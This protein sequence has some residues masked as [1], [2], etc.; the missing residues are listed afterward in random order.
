[1]NRVWKLFLS[2]M[3]FFHLSAAAVSAR[4]PEPGDTEPQETVLPER[5]EI[6]EEAKEP[7]EETSSETEPYEPEPAGE[8]TGIIGEQPPSEESRGLSEEPEEETGGS[9]EDSSELEDSPG[10]YKRTIMLYL[11]GCD[12]ETNTGNATR[13]LLQML[14]ASFSGDQEIC[15]LV[16]TGGAAAGTEGGSAGPVWKMESRYL[17]D[18]GSELQPEHISDE[19]NQVWELRGKDAAEYASKMILLDADGVSG[20]GEDAK[21]SDAE[22]M[23]DPETLKKFINY[24]VRKCPAEK[25]DLILWDH[26]GGFNNGFALDQHDKGNRGMMRTSGFFGALADNEVTKNGGKFE[27]INFDACLM[28]TIEIEVLLSDYANYYLASAELVPGDGEYYTGWLDELGN[29]PGL[30][31]AELGKKAVDDYVWYYTEKAPRSGTMALFDLQKLADS[32][33]AEALDELVDVLESQ[34]RNPEEALYYDELISSRTSIEYSD[35]GYFDLGGLARVFDVPLTEYASME[36]VRTNTN[37]YAEPAGKI[38]SILNDQSIVYARFAGQDNQKDIVHR[39]DDGTLSYGTMYSSGTHLIFPKAPEYGNVIS[40]IEEMNRILA[41]MNPDDPRYA[42]FRKYLAAAADYSLV[43]Q[44]GN[45][46]SRYLEDGP[47]DISYDIVKKIWQTPVYESVPDRTIWDVKIAP[48]YAAIPGGE[49]VCTAWLEKV[50]QQMAKEAVYPQKITTTA[51]RGK[52]RDEW[53]VTLKNTKRRVIRDI[54]YSPIAHLP[55]VTAYVESLPEDYRKALGNLD[56]G[57]VFKLTN[58]TAFEDI[59]D[60]G[61][62]DTDEYYENYLKWMNS[63]S[64]DWMIHPE[65]DKLYCIRDEKNTLHVCEATSLG[66]EIEVQILATVDGKASN[67]VLRF[68][69]EDRLSAI[70]FTAGES[71][72]FISPDTL[73]SEISAMP[74]AGYAND[75]DAFL[76][77]ISLSPI[78]ISAGNYTSI[79]LNYEDIK[80]IPDIVNPTGTG[81]LSVSVT[82]TDIY[83]YGHNITDL[84]KKPDKE[85][86]HIEYAELNRSVYNGKEQGPVLTISGRTLKEGRDYS[87]VKLD[88]EQSFLKPGNYAVYLSGEGDFGGNIQAAF[89]IDPRAIAETGIGAVKPQRYTG[90]PLTPKPVIRIGDVVLTENEDYI[91]SYEDNIGPGTG[92]IHITGISGCTGTADLNFEIIEEIPVYCAVKGNGQIWTRGSSK[93]AEFVFRRSFSDSETFGHF[94]GI[95]IDGMEADDSAYTAESGSLILNLRPS[96]LNT[97]SRGSHTVT[98]MFD[99]GEDAAA[100]FAVYVPGGGKDEESSQDQS[101]PSAYLPLPQ[102]KNQVVNT[103]DHTNIP[104]W[105]AMLG[106]SLLFTAFSWTMLRKAGR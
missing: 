26:G 94:T 11:D 47:R 59:S 99:D 22:L 35:T 14:N 9:E 66:E 79:F 91:L 67:A 50:I 19:Y 42:M 6:N 104:Y 34:V 4:E 70:G 41:G 103:A 7:E 60:F 46:V 21:K 49:A 61:D 23:S 98:A 64:S 29:N 28:S 37:R 52:E 97:L 68:D 101:G 24:C 88:E 62:P 100:E 30:S 39:D 16:L 57:E 2:A 15:L 85:K 102:A 106:I 8:E 87:W 105:T 43:I 84:F 45:T 58:V 17:A 32:G 83:G 10:L 69:S 20:D 72:R 93:P 54:T 3:M 13:N 55:A 96:Y 73:T 76:I 82:L 18:P 48:L 77:P 1:M 12:L 31:T 44:T 75:V 27:L 74:V 25:Y 92:V 51:I 89:A 56:D 90:S 63:D 36:D 86:V 95:R 33:I 71:T 38:R 65:T 81:E 5:E 40:C 78:T 53:E 80:E